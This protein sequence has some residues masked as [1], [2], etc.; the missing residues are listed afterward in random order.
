MANTGYL[1]S[2]GIQ[3]VFTTGP[4]SGSIVTSSYSVG[5]TFFG[6]TV[7][8]KQSFISGTVDDIYPCSDVPQIF[9]RYYL[10]PLCA[11]CITPILISGTTECINEYDF[12]YFIT[13]SNVDVLNSPST[14]IYW[15]TTSDFSSNTGSLLIDNN[16]DG[17]NLTINVSSSLTSPVPLRSTPVYFKAFNS[18]SAVLSSSF[19]NTLIVSC[20]R[21]IPTSSYSNFTLDIYNTFL[22]STSMQYSYNGSDY[23]ILLNQSS[24]ITFST[25]TLSIPVKILGLTEPSDN[26]IFIDKLEGTIEGIVATVIT[27]K[28]SEITNITSPTEYPGTSIINI[29]SNNTTIDL[30]IDIDR[31][32]FTNTGK[33]RVQIT[34]IPPLEPE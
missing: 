20:S 27:D 21:S 7:D 15:S 23:N 30:T 29:D 10:D 8:F 6:P 17:E 9:Y 28:R 33:I 31:N 22:G 3:Q 24:S 13:R 14:I 19:S 34:S 5:S 1:T 18:C 4:L 25:E 11:A 32:T 16:I 26:T 2:S 12:N